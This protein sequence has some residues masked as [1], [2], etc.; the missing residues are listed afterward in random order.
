MMGLPFLFAE[1]KEASKTNCQSKSQ[2]CPIGN[3][4]KGVTKHEGPKEE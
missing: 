3:R 2:S 1:K 4:Q